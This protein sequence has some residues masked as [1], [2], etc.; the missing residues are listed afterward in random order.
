MGDV[1]KKALALDG[2]DDGER[3]ISLGTYHGYA[4]V[5]SISPHMRVGTCEVAFVM[6]YSHTCGE[7]R[8]D[9]F[10]SAVVLHV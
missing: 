5:G 4:C 9:M 1:Y 8:V 10:V 3:C 7:T 2:V 6:G